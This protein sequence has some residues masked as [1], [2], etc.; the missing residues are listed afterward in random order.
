M[1][2]GLGLVSG[3][4]IDSRSVGGGGRGWWQWWRVWE[5]GWRLAMIM[6]S[7]AST[8]SN[9]GTGSTISIGCWYWIYTIGTT[10]TNTPTIFTINRG[11]MKL[12]ANYW[13]RTVVIINVRG[14][15][16]I[17]H[18][19]VAVIEVWWMKIEQMGTGILWR[20][21]SRNS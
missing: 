7:T 3:G 5:L 8:S 14:D 20:N 18:R 9:T 21:V 11:C 17:W 16:N 6:I 1:I 13:C 19:I 10:I 4:S 15:V 2:I 12:T